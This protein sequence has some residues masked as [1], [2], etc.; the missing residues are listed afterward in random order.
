MHV[1]L[2]YCRPQANIRSH[3]YNPCPIIPIHVVFCPQ[4]TRAII[5]AM[6]SWRSIVD[7]YFTFSKWERR[8]IAVIWVVIVALMIF[9]YAIAPNRYARP[10]AAD[11]ATLA[12]VAELKLQTD[13]LDRAEWSGR[14]ST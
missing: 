8:A 2:V 4:Q 11:A 9:Q 12:A 5:E 7:S 6:N 10:G 13:S 3:Q 1:Q 14:T